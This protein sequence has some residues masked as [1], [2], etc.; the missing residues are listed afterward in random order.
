MRVYERLLD[1]WRLIV[2]RKTYEQAS[3]GFQARA[4]TWCCTPPCALVV[5]MNL[6]GSNRLTE[7]ALSALSILSQKMFPLHDDQAFDRDASVRF[8]EVFKRIPTDSL[9]QAF[10]LIKMHRKDE[11]RGL[12]GELKRLATLKNVSEIEAMRFSIVTAEKSAEEDAQ[13]CEELV[14][15]LLAQ[16]AALEALRDKAASECSRFAAH[17]DQTVAEV[18][19][20]RHQLRELIADFNTTTAQKQSAHEQ[21]VKRLRKI[22]NDLVAQLQ[23]EHASALEKATDEAEAKIRARQAEIEAEEREWRSNYEEDC[24]LASVR[25]SEAEAARQAAAWHPPVLPAAAVAVVPVTPSAPPP[26][27]SFAPPTVALASESI[28]VSFNVVLHDDLATVK[29]RHSVHS[30]LPLSTLRDELELKSEDRFCL[31]SL[32]P[33]TLPKERKMTVAE[34]A[35][36]TRDALLVLRVRDTSRK[37]L[38]SDA[39]LPAESVAAPLAVPAP[40]MSLQQSTLPTP[41]APVSAPAHDAMLLVRIVQVS[42]GGASGGEVKKTLPV[43]EVSVTR[44]ATLDVLRAAIRETSFA[45][46]QEWRFLSGIAPVT[47]AKEKTMSVVEAFI[48]NPDQPSTIWIKEKN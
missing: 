46:P 15:A 8:L 44:Q 10:T 20:T 6:A 33:L 41:P 1:S 28:V 26:P 37:W 12:A 16:H 25:A 45:F 7:D 40:A 42:L 21:A 43:G 27:L 2:C 5:A 13:R 32:D 29:C 3:S 22:R 4:A 31:A 36:Q 47:P 19:K 38:N 9:P 11:L 24:R 39:S 30:Q 35:A 18:R 48:S 17:R 23:Q 14:T 34:Y